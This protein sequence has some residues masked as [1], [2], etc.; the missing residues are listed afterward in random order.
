M[1]QSAKPSKKKF[2]NNKRGRS[3]KPPESALIVFAKSPVPGSVKTR[4]CP[5]LTPDEAAT[6][7]GSLVMDT[8]ERTKNLQGVDRILA[9]APSQQHPFFQAVSAR[10][11]IA[12]WEQIPDDDLG[13]RMA[14]AFSEAF[15]KNYTNAVM[16]GSD[17]PTISSEIIQQAVQGLR[18]HD[19]V[20]G[21]SHDGGYYLIGLKKP[22]PELFF[23]IPWSTHQVTAL[24]KQKASDLGLSLTLLPVQ[25]DLDTIEDLQFYIK[26]SPNSLQKAV[27]SR[28][29]QVFKTLG[30]RLVNR[31]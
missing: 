29:G 12:L 22:N 19:V 24:T 27:S 28:T 2:P 25:R 6:L 16:I 26:E 14:H 31:E 3:P 18:K 23:D 30:T 13:A 21:P 8:L 9:C 15:T 17:L 1:A 20:I 11:H 5:P 7:H 4:L 10:Q